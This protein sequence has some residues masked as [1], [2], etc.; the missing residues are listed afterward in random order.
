MMTSCAQHFCR[1]GRPSPPR[2]TCFRLYIFIAVRPFHPSDCYQKYDRLFNLKSFQCTFDAGISETRSL[3][4]V[5]TSP[6]PRRLPSATSSEAIFRPAPHQVTWVAIHQ[7]TRSVSESLL[8][9]KMVGGMWYFGC[10]RLSCGPT[11]HFP[12]HRS[13]STWRELGISATDSGC[14][15]II[16]PVDCLSLFVGI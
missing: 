12:D 7:D 5:V 14:A 10:G 1:G 16:S 15:T 9:L 2:G 11:D 13:I 4:N 3:D 6:M 8:G